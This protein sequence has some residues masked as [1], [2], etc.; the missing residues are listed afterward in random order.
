MKRQA[1]TPFNPWEMLSPRLTQ[2]FFDT[3]LPSPIDRG[4]IA[5]VSK[6][7]RKHV[8]ET[9]RQWSEIGLRERL[10][11]AKEKGIDDVVNHL[12]F[13]TSAKIW[14]DHF[15]ELM[16]AGDDDPLRIVHYAIDSGSELICDNFRPH[17]PFAGHDDLN[18]LYLVVH[19]DISC[20]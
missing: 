9:T 19:T 15:V 7:F 1:T 2:W 14:H 12:L 13:N 16:R 18:G 8:S 5:Q 10:L 4:R 6:H 17:E 3:Y 20:Y 11:I